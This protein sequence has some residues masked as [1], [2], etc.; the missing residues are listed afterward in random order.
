[1]YEELASIR[2]IVDLSHDAALDEAETFLTRLG[3]MSVQRT[4][5][6]LSTER[7][8]SDRAEG[9]EPFGLTVEVI[10]Q[11]RGGVRLRVMGNDREGVRERQAAWTE[12]S[13]SLPK[14]PDAQT[15]QSGDWQHVTETQNVSL[16][17]SPPRA[18]TFNLPPAPQA[19]PPSHP[20]SLPS[21]QGSAVWLG[22][23]LAF[24]ACIVLPMLIVIVLMIL[25]A[26]LRLF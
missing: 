2:S 12:W 10:P 25:F 3:Y 21:R 26:V 19:S 23:K 20:V 9:Q 16:P 4:E 18:E 5:T 15:A 13:E 6:S 17:S 24:G 11:S 22:V 7:R 1:M 8:Q 14:K